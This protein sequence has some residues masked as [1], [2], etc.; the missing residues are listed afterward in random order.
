MIKTV[1]DEWLREQTTTPS[2]NGWYN[3]IVKH[4]MR[5]NST[6]P[7]SVSGKKCWNASAIYALLKTHPSEL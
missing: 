6:R 3:L 1:T 7:Y 5:K 4:M 2:T